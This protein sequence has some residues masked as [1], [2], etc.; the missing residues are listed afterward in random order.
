MFDGHLG[1][2]LVLGV[3]PKD[4]K[5]CLTAIL[6]AILFWDYAQGCQSGINRILLY[7]PASQKCHPVLYAVAREC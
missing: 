1:W 5:T 7:I 4:G 6:D 3:M 2:H